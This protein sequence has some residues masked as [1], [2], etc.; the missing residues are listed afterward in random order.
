MSTFLSY[1]YI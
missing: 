1:E